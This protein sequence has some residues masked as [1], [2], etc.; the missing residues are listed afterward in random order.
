MTDRALLVLDQV[1]RNALDSELTLRGLSSS[2]KVLLDY[3]PRTTPVGHATISTGSPPSVHRVQGRTWCENAAVPAT[4]QIGHAVTLTR[5]R[6][7]DPLAALG[8]SSLA[9]QLRAAKTRGIVGVA[10]KDFIPFVFGAWDCDVSVYPHDVSPAPLASPKGAVGLTIVF[11]AWTSAGLAALNLAW[12]SILRH[13][14]AM[15]PAGT[16]VSAPTP[17]AVG[18]VPHRHTATWRFPAA[19]GTAK[20]T[21]KPHWSGYL[22]GHAEDIDDGYT[23]IA[24]ELL[25]HLPQPR[26]HLQ[27]CFSSDAHGHA[28]GHGSPAHVTAVSRGVDR[29]IRLGT[30]GYKVGV[31]SDHGGRLTPQVALYDQAMSTVDGFSLP[32]AASVHFKDGDHIVGYDTV[33]PSTPRFEFRDAATLSPFTVPPAIVRR[34]YHPLQ[35]PTWKVVGDHDTRVVDRPHPGGGGDHGVCAVASTATLSPIDNEVPAWSPNATSTYSPVTL[36]DIAQWFLG[37]T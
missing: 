18:A 16:S 25:R 7:T 22:L 4:M 31:T 29:A 33:P 6:A 13:M 3:I 24:Q 21:W 8:H 20:L 27:S 37:L 14:V 9:A 5:P 11:I 17:P 30:H 32:T 1:S 15:A 26:A 28:S 12:A 19:W 35:K 34:S 10:A 2:A 23:D 36:D